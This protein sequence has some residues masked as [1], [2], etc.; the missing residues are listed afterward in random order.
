[1]RAN[2]R[3]TAFVL[4]V[5]LAVAVLQGACGLAA[6]GSDTAIQRAVAFLSAEVPKWERENHCFSC[7]NNGDA[8]RALMWAHHRG[9]LLDR[10]PLDDTLKFLAAPRSGTPT[11][12]MGRSRT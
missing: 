4:A 8:A 11:D 10:K 2:R 3:T 6:D 9:K 7:H 5:A 12:R 1:M